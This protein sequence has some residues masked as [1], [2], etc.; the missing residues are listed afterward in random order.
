MFTRRPALSSRLSDLGSK[1]YIPANLLSVTYKVPLRKLCVIFRRFGDH[2]KFSPL[3][4]NVS[5]LVFTK[6]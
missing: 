6:K 1:L 3:L 4:V 5:V 2:Y